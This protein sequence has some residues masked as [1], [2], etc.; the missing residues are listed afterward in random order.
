LRSLLEINPSQALKP[1]P[2]S[3][4]SKTQEDGKVHERKVPHHNVGVILCWNIESANPTK[5]GRRQNDY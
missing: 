2:E 5:V 4:L 3:V 1:Q